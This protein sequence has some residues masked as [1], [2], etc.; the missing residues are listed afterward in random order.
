MKKIPTVTIGIA[1][2][3]EEHNLKKLIGSLLRQKQHN[4]KLENIIVTSDGSTDKTAETVKRYVRRGSIVHLKVNRKNKGQNTTQNDL[5]KNCESDFLILIE[6]DTVPSDVN[7]LEKLLK[8][9]IQDKRVDLVIGNSKP[10]G[11]SLCAQCLIHQIET[12]RK[13]FVETGECWDVS[14]RG[15]KALRVSSFENFAW[16]K[17]SPEDSYVFF[18]ALQHG[19]KV[20]KSFT[21]TNLFRVE[22]NIFEL[23]KNRKKVKATRN[24]IQDDFDP[25]ITAYL[26][27]NL[28]IRHLQAFLY[29]F[30]RQPLQALVFLAIKIYVAL[31]MINTEFNQNHYRT[32]SSR[33]VYAQD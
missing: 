25:E 27:P 23:I 21:A 22:N 33:M 1:A 26:Y 28:S 31:Y 10:L 6:A 19:L 11:V 4:F 29:F 8:P 30:G 7:Y 15:G 14:G 24:K 13:F 2:Y 32:S 18:W 16:T 3:N 5:L 12:Y 20:E 17:S 9:M